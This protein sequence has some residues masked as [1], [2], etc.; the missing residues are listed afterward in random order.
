M[1]YAERIRAIIAEYRASDVDDED[2][3]M[4]RLDAA[5]DEN[6]EALAL[7]D[8]LIQRLMHIGAVLESLRDGCDEQE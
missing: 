7:V 2:D 1:D 6:D 8:E 5:I 4:A 3:I